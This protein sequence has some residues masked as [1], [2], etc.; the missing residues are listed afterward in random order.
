MSAD[1]WCTVND[2]HQHVALD[3]VGH[4]WKLL[5]TGV[6]SGSLQIRLTICYYNE[7]T[8]MESY[9][10]ALSTTAVTCHMAV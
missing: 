10:A 9:V 1:I 3:H 4:C 2:G 6:A 8:K 5:S 7:E